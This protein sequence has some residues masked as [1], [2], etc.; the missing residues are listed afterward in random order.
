MHQEWAALTIE[1][2][3]SV[4]G[5]VEGIV[6]YFT[7]MK[8]GNPNYQELSSLYNIIEM[9][10]EEMSKF[11][12]DNFL[13]G[14]VVSNEVQKLKSL[15]SATLKLK[16]I[17]NECSIILK[18]LA[19]TPSPNTSLT[20]S[21]NSNTN[22]KT[23]TDKSKSKNNDNT[24]QN[25]TKPQPQQPAIRL[26]PSLTNSQSNPDKTFLKNLPPPSK[27][28]MKK[29]TPHEGKKPLYDW[30]LRDEPKAPPS[31]DMLLSFSQSSALVKSVAV[32]VVLSPADYELFQERKW[33]L[34]RHALP[35]GTHHYLHKNSGRL[36]YPVLEND[37]QSKEPAEFE[38]SEN[39]ND[40][41]F[42]H[43]SMPFVDRYIQEKVA[44]R[45]DMKGKWVSPAPFA[46]SKTRPRSPVTPKSPNSPLFDNTQVEK[47][48]A[49]FGSFE[50]FAENLRRPI[51][52][53]PSKSSPSLHKK[54]SP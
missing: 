33:K 47:V 28:L 16:E 19:T 52:T 53:S 21:N 54:G 41:I 9:R 17:L 15:F 38:N 34:L 31:K 11:Y 49:V 42:L 36:A 6:N 40:S 5:E 12:N 37:T 45:D 24:P 43:S 10:M 1:N 18:T 29:F 23:N 3:D 26:P 7:K 32:R 44:T 25:E 50:L 30:E 27:S 39:R 13:E 35:T 51:H 4:S 20:A 22:T 14:K 48:P 2:L 46:H 8:V